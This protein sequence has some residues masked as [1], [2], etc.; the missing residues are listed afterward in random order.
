MTD[1]ADASRPWWAWAS[2]V[3]LCVWLVAVFPYAEQ[4]RNANER[5]RLIQAMAWVE[6]GHWRIDGAAARGLAAGPDVARG[7]DGG[8]YPNKPPGTT[9]VAAAG[10]VAAR[11]LARFQGQPLTL[12]HYTWWARLVTAVIPT[13]VLAWVLVRWLVPVFGRRRSLAAVGLVLVAT[14]LAAYARLVYGHALAACLV[15]CGALG[16]IEG[17][18]RD[19]PGL[20]AGAAV[21]A[22]SAVVVEYSA[23]F[24][25]VPLAVFVGLSAWAGR[26]RAAVAAMLGAAVPLLGLAAYHLHAFGSPWRTGYHH[27]VDPSFAAKHG[28]GLLGLVAPNLAAV[29][30]HIVSVEAGLVWWAPLAVLGVWGLVIAARAADPGPLRSHARVHLAMVLCAVAAAVSLNFEGGWRVGPRYLVAALPGL[31]L[32]FAVALQ[33][34]QV[35]RPGLRAGAWVLVAAATTWS[36]VINGLAAMLW[37]HFDLTNIH[38]PVAEVL[39]PLWWAGDQPY[40][41]WG[42]GVTPV[43]VVALLAVLGL[44]APPGRMRVALVSG[45]VLGVA[46]V[47]ATSTVTPHPRGAAN[48]AYI[49]KVWEPPATGEPAPSAV[50]RE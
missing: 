33:W 1:A 49:R 44:L 40:T 16:V 14:P 47:A 9:I 29:H 21:V 3:G 38:H 35:Q 19:R 2:L 17:C 22:A 50:L 26:W 41:W 15:W 25:G 20:A 34:L 27:V 18:R 12:R 48:L 10:Y 42:L 6:A 37:P 11:S 28:E 30:A 4:T 36:V 45:V 7:H 5:P 32:G 24:L 43:V 8:L 39:L 31:V 13:L 46:G 23:A